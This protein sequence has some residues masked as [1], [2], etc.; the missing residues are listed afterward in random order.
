MNPASIIMFS[1]QITWQAI[2][3]AYIADLPMD[4]VQAV[5]TV[6]F[7]FFGAKPLIEKMERV[8]VKWG[9]HKK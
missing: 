4:L 8:Q 1:S 2:V 6:I 3:G 5:A 7:L 9:L